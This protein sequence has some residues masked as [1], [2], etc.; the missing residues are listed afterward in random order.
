MGRI[1]DIRGALA[2]C[3]H[4]NKE[5]LTKAQV[6]AWIGNSFRDA[7]FNPNTLQAQ[8][9][10]SCVNSKAKTSA[11]KILWYEKSNKTY[12]LRLPTDPTNED[13]V[14]IADVESEEEIE[15]QAGST[16]A[17]EAHLRDY[18]ARNLTILEKG[19][20]LWSDSPPS[21]EYSI[22]N[23]RID[24]LAKDR[25]GVPVVVELKLS[26][27]HERTLGQALYYR[28]KLKQVLKVSR[29]RIIMVAAEITDELRIASI[30]VTDV[31]VFSY[32]LTMQV[33]KID[34]NSVENVEGPEEMALA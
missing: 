4:A 20:R 31:D 9:Y 34:F 8:L 28:G 5:P 29:V 27:G 7:D 24:I 32:R 2:A 6:F 10:R 16:F 19:L 22:D 25:D 26:R 33:Q 14:A 12:R 23:R 18:L 1:Q 21:V 13:Q 11:P 30:E 17:L 3:F 15:F